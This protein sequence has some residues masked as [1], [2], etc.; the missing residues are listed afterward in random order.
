MSQYILIILGLSRKL[1]CKARYNSMR[2]AV[3]VDTLRLSR[4]AYDL[5]EGTNLGDRSVVD[6][7]QVSRLRVDLE[8]AEEAHSSLHPSRCYG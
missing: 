1:Q 5:R 6:V 8:G 3:P 7:D 4:Q 2:I